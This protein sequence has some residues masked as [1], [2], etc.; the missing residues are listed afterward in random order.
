[1]SDTYFSCPICKV[2]YRYQTIN[3]KTTYYCV[4]HKNRNNSKSQ[5]PTNE[6]Y[7]PIKCSGWYYP[8]SNYKHNNH[9]LTQEL[10]QN[11]SYNPEISHKIA[12]D[13][14]SKCRSLLTSNPFIIVP[15]PNYDSSYR[16]GVS[17]ASELA[18]I[19][20]EHNPESRY[21]DALEKLTS[22]SAHTLPSWK[23][24]EYWAKPVY[25]LIKSE[26]ISG[27]RI[28]LIDDIQSTGK[29]IFH[30]VKELNKANPSKIYTYVAART[31]HYT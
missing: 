6:R 10:L 7:T 16:A 31:F 22:I 5:A 23:K 30:C 20:K 9:Q 24:E 3:G 1:M 14:F 29:T 19:M 28:L 25:R 4:K 17:I 2:P 8:T 21:V 11:K 27:Q 15:V 12:N 13:M 18:S 26:E